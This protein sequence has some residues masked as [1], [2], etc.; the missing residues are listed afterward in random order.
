M[1]TEEAGRPSRG[2]AVAGPPVAE[3]RTHKAQGYRLAER[4]DI[5]W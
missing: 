5:R 4:E 3:L 2:Q 1:Y